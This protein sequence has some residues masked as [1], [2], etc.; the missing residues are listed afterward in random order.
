MSSDLRRRLERLERGRPRAQARTRRRARA[1]D[2]PPGEEVETAE[3]LAYRIDT[4]YA[5]DYR[6]GRSSL[7]EVLSYAPSL[8]AEVATWP[9]S[10]SMSRDRFIMSFDGLNEELTRREMSE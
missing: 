4:R 6:H 10:I 2:L 9:K 1:H 8:A 7:R 5:V 3:G